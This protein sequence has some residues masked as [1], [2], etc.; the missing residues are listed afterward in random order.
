MMITFRDYMGKTDNAYGVIKLFKESILLRLL[1]T[2]WGR[3][4]CML[5]VVRL[6]KTKLTQQDNKDF[7]ITNRLGRVFI[8]IIMKIL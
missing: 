2:Y 7:S 4:V 6:L 5:K 1:I 3:R 8:L